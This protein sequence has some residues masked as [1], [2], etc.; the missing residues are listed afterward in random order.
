MP[1]TFSTLIYTHTLL[2][3]VDLVD[4]W[5]LRQNLIGQFLGSRQHLRV[6]DRNQVLDKLLQLVSAHLKQGFWDG[7]VQFDLLGLPY[8]IKWQRHYMGAVEDVFVATCA[9]YR[10]DLAAVEA[11]TDAAYEFWGRG[12][13]G[14]RHCAAE[15]ET[16]KSEKGK[17]CQALQYMMRE[18]NLFFLV[19][20][21][22]GKDFNKKYFHQDKRYHL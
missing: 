11:D 19:H 20:K 7:Q 4:L 6:V 13:G 2:L 9:C 8:S 15:M 18:L 14:V 16:W 3:T 12:C 1:V 21:R 5:V 22:K 10:R 17:F